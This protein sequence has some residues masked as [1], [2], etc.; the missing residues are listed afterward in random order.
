MSLSPYR[1]FNNLSSWC[2]F[3][4]IPCLGLI[5][6]SRVSLPVLCKQTC[7]RSWEHDRKLKTTSIEITI[8]IVCYR[9]LGNAWTS[10]FFPTPVCYCTTQVTLQMSFLAIIFLILSKHFLVIIFSLIRTSFPRIISNASLLNKLPISLILDRSN[11]DD[12]LMR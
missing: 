3:T 11:F 10:K 4:L 2:S 8:L 9:R 5:H 12:H 7:D 1:L 6:T